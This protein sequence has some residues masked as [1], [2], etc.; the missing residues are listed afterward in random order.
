M[1]H[2]GSLPGAGHAGL[3]GDRQK[4]SPHREMGGFA[5]AR[6]P[7]FLAGAAVMAV[8]NSSVMLK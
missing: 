7:Y 6:P 3:P 5:F 4:K 1:P 8:A 2:D